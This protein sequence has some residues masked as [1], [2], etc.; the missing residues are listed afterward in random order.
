MRRELPESLPAEVVAAGETIAR[1]FAGLVAEHLAAGSRPGRIAQG[2][3]PLGPRRHCA[4][5]RRR[6]RDGA[7]GAW[8]V[9]RD[10]YLSE[11]ALTEE[12]SRGTK[13][14]VAKATSVT[15]ELSRELRIVGGRR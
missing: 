11:Q 12:M 8:V 6:L 3:S 9:G 15:E 13:A 7:D 2:A 1:W 14:R 10:F 4:A 5:V